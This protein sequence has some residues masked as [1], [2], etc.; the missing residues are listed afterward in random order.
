MW[1]K[2]I[3]LIKNKK[4]WVMIS[5]ILLLTVSTGGTLAYLVEKTPTVVNTFKSG[6]SPYG[7]LRISK[8]IEHPYGDSYSLPDGLSFS[9]DVDV[10]IGLSG[11]ELGNYTVNDSGIIHLTFE[12]DES[13][14]IPEIPENTVVTVTETSSRAGFAAQNETLSTTVEATK[15]HEISF[16]NIYTPSSAPCS[17]LN[18]TAVKH[19]E[20]R[21]WLDTDSFTFI[22]EYKIKESDSWIALG[23]PVVVN[24]QS[25]FID[26]STRSFD[27]TSII[28]T[29]DLSQRATYLFRLT[30]VNVPGYMIPSV[31][32]FAVVTDD[33][34]M[35]GFL[36][37][38]HVMD[39]ENTEI[40]MSE[41]DYLIELDVTNAY[42]ITGDTG[43]RIDITKIFEDAAN[44]SVNRIPSGF[45]FVLDDGTNQ[46]ESNPTG[47]DG[48][49][50]FMPD[51]LAEDT[52]KVFT[53]LLSEKNT[54]DSHIDYD[55]KQVK[56]HV[57]VKD[58]GDGS[59]SAVIFECTG[60]DL[61]LGEVSPLVIT[62]DE[63]LV[64]N[65]DVSLEPDESPVSTSDPDVTSSPEAA[66]EHDV[67]SEPVICTVPENGSS[68]FAVSFKNLYTPDEALL[69][70]SGHKQFNKQLEDNM[71]E[72]ILV[73]TD[74]SYNVIEHGKE[75]TVSNVADG[76]SFTDI[77]FSQA[78]TEHY[79]LKEKMPAEAV[80]GV[81][82]GI[83]YD[84]IE[85]QLKIQISEDISNPGLLKA[86]VVDSN[87]FVFNN[88]YSVSPVQVELSASKSFTGDGAES[89]TDEFYIEIYESEDDSFT[90][91][92]KIDTK[93]IVHS[94]DVKFAFEVSEPKDYYYV[95]KEN[96]DRQADGVIYDE[97]QF[98]I[99]LHVKDNLDGTMSYEITKILK[100][101]KD[102]TSEEVTSAV[103]ENKYYPE[104]I[105]HT[106]TGKKTLE[107]AT[108]VTNQFTFELYRTDESY[109]ISGIICEETKNDS[110]GYFSFTETYDH[111]GTYWYVIKEKD[112]HDSTPQI[113][114]DTAEY[115]IK[116][117]VEDQNG[118]LEVTEESIIDLSNGQEAQLKFHNLAEQVIPEDIFVSL[119]VKKTVKNT[120]T[121]IRGPEGF[122]FILEKEGTEIAKAISDKDGNAVFTL[123]LSE[124]DLGSSSYRIIELHENEAYITYSTSAY[125][126]EIEVHKEQD[127]L[128]SQINYRGTETDSLTVEFE[129][130]YHHVIKQPN[131][132]DTGDDS[133]FLIYAL[134]CIAALI[135]MIVLSL[136]RK[137]ST[138]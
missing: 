47:L 97:S 41:S 120:G 118:H 127:R 28:Q 94:G 83:A 35:D 73:Q 17:S 92:N 8:K 82:K 20:G 30:E 123:V 106:F 37:I 53:Y 137:K 32:S 24:H 38:S 86:E 88:V 1:N 75:Y 14:I 64:S 22:V 84:P 128:N 77:A 11:A 65:P 25:N 115:G 102:G 63:P 48:T 124:K 16:T 3:K 96:T 129:N 52:G 119:H 95:L 49:A 74:S 69:T 126:F 44:P 59:V 34:D 125:D 9:F 117:V 36:E 31:D 131:A 85:Y 104:S 116:I 19:I 103:F 132:I 99:T 108:L 121:E 72:F 91:L 18:V 109:N 12:H 43:V 111:S 42:Q 55:D 21:E 79:L 105:N 81:Y 60:C 62:N 133:A 57:H 113:Q 134:V 23:S 13:V 130:I 27:L 54:G 136:L 50:F 87:E 93:S 70:I 40:L 45:V 112:E 138:K 110:D 107:N 67:S 26:E 78:G 80:N 46:I 10:G 71:F 58:N 33:I 122:V 51:Y 114:F 98:Y 29:A 6:I 5:L 89:R 2:F 39:S 68:V 61:E 15:T 56:V 101:M 76:F 100:M 90:V 7:G 4:S 135:A 66:L